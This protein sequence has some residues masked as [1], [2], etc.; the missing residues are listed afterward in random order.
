MENF[1]YYIFC[2]IALV[3]GIVLFKKVAGCLIKTIVFAVIIAALAVVWYLYF[4]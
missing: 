3:I 1:M 2:L 4:K